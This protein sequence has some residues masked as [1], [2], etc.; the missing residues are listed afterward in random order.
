[1]DRI[2]LKRFFLDHVF[3]FACSCLCSQVHEL[4]TPNFSTSNLVATFPWSNSKLFSRQMFLKNAKVNLARLSIPS[5][6]KLFF[7][8]C[9]KLIFSSPSFMWFSPFISSSCSFGVC[10]VFFV[11]IVLFAMGNLF[12]YWYGN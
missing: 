8:T 9:I 12:T 11:P 4:T 2:F 7:T 1:M 10:L 3:M 5:H 6:Y